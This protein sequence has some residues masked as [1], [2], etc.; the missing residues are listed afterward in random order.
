MADFHYPFT[1]TFS[2]SGVISKGKNVSSDNNWKHYIQLINTADM[3]ILYPNKLRFVLLPKKYFAAEDFEQ[4]SLLVK[5]KV[6]CQ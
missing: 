4:L 3:I 2:E 5:D 6:L 1:F